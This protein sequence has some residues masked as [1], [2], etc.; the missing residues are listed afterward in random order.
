MVMSAGTSGFSHIFFLAERVPFS[1]STQQPAVQHL[2]V[3]LQ[4]FTGTILEVK[5]HAGVW[6]GYDLA[7]SII[8]A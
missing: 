3:A 8:A 4:P 1:V 6:L 2:S 7:L 5:V